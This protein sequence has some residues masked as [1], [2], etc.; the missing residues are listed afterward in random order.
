MYKYFKFYNTHCS[1]RSKI[2]KDLLQQER[3]FVMWAEAMLN[4]ERMC[5]SV[6]LIG[7]RELLRDTCTN[8]L[9]LI[10][11]ITQKKL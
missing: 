2:Q 7:L 4:T 5:D 6:F 11:V 8:I 1:L 3:S 10:P 9:F